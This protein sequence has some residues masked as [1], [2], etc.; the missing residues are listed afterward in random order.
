MT[1]YWDERRR[2]LDLAKEAPEA[3]KAIYEKLA[4][5]PATYEATIKFQVRDPYLELGDNPTALDLNSVITESVLAELAPEWFTPK[6]GAG[7]WIDKA[8]TAKRSELQRIDSTY[9]D[10]DGSPAQGDTR[11]EIAGLENA[12]HEANDKLGVLT[13]AGVEAGLD[14]AVSYIKANADDIAELFDGL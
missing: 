13:H 10:G 2:L 12:L 4:A 7:W 8:S 14:W 5:E 9:L 11:A 1:I 3:S 6:W